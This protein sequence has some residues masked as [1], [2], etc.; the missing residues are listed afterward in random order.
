MMW[1][2]GRKCSTCGR[3]SLR[4][5]GARARGTEWFGAGGYYRWSKWSPCSEHAPGGLFPWESRFD[6]DG[7]L[8]DLSDII[9]AA[10]GG[11]IE[12]VNQ[13]V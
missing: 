3:R 7:G 6:A 9:P 1:R 4:A 2:L 10:E 11:G 12:S 13:V 8:D 5:C